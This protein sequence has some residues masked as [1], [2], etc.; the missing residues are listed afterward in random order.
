MNP[1]KMLENTLQ[2]NLEISISEKLRQI[3]LFCSAYNAFH[4]A[5]VW[6]F[7]LKIAQYLP[8]HPVSFL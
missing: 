2:W 8:S 1:L 6:F 7:P 3:G 4:T 5:H